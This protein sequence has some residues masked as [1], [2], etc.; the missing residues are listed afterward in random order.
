M[1]VFVRVYTHVYTLS[2]THTRTQAYW[3]HQLSR[4]QQPSMTNDTYTHTH[5]QVASVLLNP[6]TV[7]SLTDDD[8]EQP[9]ALQMAY[10]GQ[11]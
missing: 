10:G 6:T 2:L 1:S 3:L 8:E 9:L 7:D 11:A 5:T 4:T